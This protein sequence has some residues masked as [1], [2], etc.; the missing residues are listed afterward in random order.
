MRVM[1]RLILCAL[2]TATA[3]GAEGEAA[4]EPDAEAK[5]AAAQEARKKYHQIRQKLREYQKKAAEDE[6]VLALK[7]VADEAQAAYK[8]KLEEKIKADPEGAAL[9]QEREAM[10][11]EMK[12]QWEARRAKHGQAQGDRQR[13]RD[14]AAARPEGVF[15]EK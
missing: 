1:L 12:K 5:R 8:A 10:R 3:L 11:E 9:L 6:E 7:K 4:A 13:T 14:K 2:L 15:G